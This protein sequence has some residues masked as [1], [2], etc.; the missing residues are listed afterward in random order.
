MQVHISAY[1]MIIAYLSICLQYIL[2]GVY[3]LKVILKLFFL[4]KRN[5]SIEWL[6][7]HVIYL[8]I[9]MFSHIVIFCRDCKFFTKEN[10]W[11][12]V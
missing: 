11:A 2:F 6:P 5:G 3:K 12:I 7:N 4:L 1:L 8:L 9:S 10:T